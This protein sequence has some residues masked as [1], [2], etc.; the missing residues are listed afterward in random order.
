MTDDC[1]CDFENAI[2]P[3][4][5]VWLCPK[6]KRDFSVEY[7]FWAEAAHPEWFEEIDK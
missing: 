6:C 4:R 3:S 7:L 5:A 2:H 1:K